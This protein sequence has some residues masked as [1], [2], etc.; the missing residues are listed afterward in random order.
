MSFERYTNKPV[1]ELRK[2]VKK[3]R[4]VKWKTEITGKCLSSDSDDIEQTKKDKCFRLLLRNTIYTN[5]LLSRRVVITGLRGGR[6]SLTH[7]TKNEHWNSST[8][9]H[10]TLRDSAESARKDES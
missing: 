5:D 10:V 6:R 7:K 1:T 9:P 2:R 4:Y 3:I 8:T